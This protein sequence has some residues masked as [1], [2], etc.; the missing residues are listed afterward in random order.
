MDISVFA[1]EL[2]GGG[3]KNAAGAKVDLRL[4]SELVRRRTLNMKDI[5]RQITE[6]IQEYS[7][8][9]KATPVEVYPLCDE[10][11]VPGRRAEGPGFSSQ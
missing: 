6:K 1:K 7:T 10:A 8:K 2:G 3:H 4:H 11:Y 9:I 5:Q